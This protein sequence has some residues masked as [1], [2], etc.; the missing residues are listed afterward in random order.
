MEKEQN[1]RLVPGADT[2]I[3]FIHGILGTPD[4]FKPFLPLVPSNWSFCNMLLKGHCGS[5]REFSAAS[6]AEWRQQ[7]HETL[8]ELQMSHDRIIIAAHSMGTL[9]AV[10]EAIKMPVDALF[11]LNT[12]LR[13]H[14]TIRMLK[15]IWGVFRGNIRPDDDWMLAAQ[16]AY[17]IERDTHLLRYLSW[18]PRYFE[19]FSEIRKTRKIVPDLTV[20]CQVYLSARDEMVSMKSGRIFENNACAAVK[21]LDS[22][23]HVYYSPEDLRFFQNEF[24]NLIQKCQNEPG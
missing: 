15:I 7:V 11:L 5:V 3:L 6:M 2:A 8:R 16:N 21:V 4:Q 17:G 18:I 12:P 24:C 23:G 13:I 1:I 22:S 9:F 10:Q 20:K 19:L 14:I